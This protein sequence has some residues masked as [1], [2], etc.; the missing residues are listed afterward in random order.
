MGAVQPPKSDLDLL[1]RA[2]GAGSS[3]AYSLENGISAKPESIIFLKELSKA[4]G[5]F[6]WDGKALSPSD[7]SLLLANLG[8][9]TTIQSIYDAYLSETNNDRKAR[10]FER[11]INGIGNPL[12]LKVMGRDL[13]KNGGRVRIPTSNW[14]AYDVPFANAYTM[15]RI[16]EYSGFFSSEVVTWAKS[17]KLRHKNYRPDLYLGDIRVFW[18]QNAAHIE[19]GEYNL[20]RP[21]S[22]VS[23]PPEDP[24]PPAAPAPLPPEPTPEPV[25]SSV[26]ASMPTPTT[27]AAPAPAAKTNHVWWIVGL[28]IL[29]VGVVFAS[30]KK[31]PKA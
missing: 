2:A 15:L 25:K 27:T 14:D 10:I 21:P 22:A 6:Y 31:T 9:L 16:A 12:L 3:L 17:I 19:A 28:I 1:F 7:T 23:K 20:V 4:K 26:A 11:V 18:A 8:D 30:R 29:A 5:P 24:N 13:S